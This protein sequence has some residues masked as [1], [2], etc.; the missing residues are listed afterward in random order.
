MPGGLVCYVSHCEWDA[1][2]Q[3]LS[4]ETLNFKEMSMQ[5]LLWH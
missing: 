2:I 4:L 1:P 3:L 5:N